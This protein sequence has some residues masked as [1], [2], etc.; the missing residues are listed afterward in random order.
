[1][2]AALARM[3]LKA[4]F[5]E[6]LGRFPEL[7]AGDPTYVVGNFVNGITTMPF[8]T[9]KPGRG[10]SDAE[11]VRGMYAAFSEL[12]D[13]RDV[14]SYVG[15]YYDPACEYHPVEETEAIRGREALVSWNQRW[16][17]AWD[18]L[19]AQVEEL[20]V[21]A[22]GAIVARIEVEGRGSASG[23]SVAQSFVH[24]ID[25]RGGRIVRMRE[26]PA[27]DEDEALGIAGLGP[28]D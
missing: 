6:L 18:A 22:S 12:A 21:S 13:G 8:A 5:T 24:V 9:G 7:E 15:T 2:G 20:R 14:E 11:V 4:I 17:E 26:F 25:L 10:P 19:R 23:M 28:G 27:E 3:Q 1:M 16:F